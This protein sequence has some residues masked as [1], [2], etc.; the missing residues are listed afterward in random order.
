M[1]ATAPNS[2]SSRTRPVWSAPE[3]R[4]AEAGRPR[5]AREARALDIDH[6]VPLAEAWES[7]ASTWTAKERETYANDLDDPRA[8]I[9][10]S[11]T[12]N[13]S[14]PDQDPAT[15]TPRPTATGAPTPPTGP[16]SKPAGTS[17]S[18]RESR[19]RSPTSWTTA[20][21]HQWKSP[22]PA[23]PPNGRPVS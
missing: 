4:K 22:S 6:L 20:R 9:A 23:E 1:R 10:V 12:S 17:P 21:T 19:P 8:L 11:A 15:W 13:R 16:P 18:T 3:N 14:K 2:S 5:S 7:G